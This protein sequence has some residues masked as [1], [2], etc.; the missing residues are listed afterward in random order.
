MSTYG[1]GLG[2]EFDTDPSLAQDEPFYEERREREQRLGNIVFSGGEDRERAIT[3]LNQLSQR[4]S[5][6]WSERWGRELTLREWADSQDNPVRFAKIESSIRKTQLAQK[7]FILDQQKAAFDQGLRASRFQFDQGKFQYEQEKDFLSFTS[8][9][10]NKRLDRQQKVVT[11]F[12]SAVTSAT[13]GLEKRSLLNTMKSLYPGLD[14]SISTPWVPLF[15]TGILSPNQMKL[16]EFDENNRPPS[17]PP[18]DSD[19]RIKGQYFLDHAEW[20]A[21]RESVK[22]GT[23]VEAKSLI[24]MDDS[25]SL[26]AR[27]SPTGLTQ[28]ITNESLVVKDLG[29]QYDRNPGEIA[30]NGGW[31]RSKKTYTRTANGVESTYAAEVSA[32]DFTDRREVLLGQKTTGGTDP[33]QRFEIPD[34]VGRVLFDIRAGLSKSTNADSLTLHRVIEGLVSTHGK[35]TA[36]VT[37]GIESALSQRFGLNFRITPVSVTK[38]NKTGEYKWMADLDVKID[39]PTLLWFDGPIFET[40]GPEF[41]VR[42]WPGQ[43]R[44]LKAGSKTGT[45]YFDYPKNRI[46]DSY[47]RFIESI[48]NYEER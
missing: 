37:K 22:R 27:R 9:E 46:F 10:R 35:D 7:K 18:D 47:G 38:N 40:T 33:Q 21:A 41:T 39:P 43:P 8:G 5:L 30:A 2:P 3:R 16:F 26:W 11:A 48:S 44:Q 34:D 14:P 20:E 4:K 13:T 28:I 6:N 23:K 15:K 36:K 29:E 19:L 31:I 17:P 25:A 12:S 45:F 24:P 32:F 1:S 42:V